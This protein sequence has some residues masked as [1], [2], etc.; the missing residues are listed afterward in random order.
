MLFV[1]LLLGCG[2]CVTVLGL[3][4]LYCVCLLGL[5][6]LACFYVLMF[7]FIAICV[8]FGFVC[9]CVMLFVSLLIRMFSNYD[10]LMFELIDVLV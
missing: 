1:I 4:L 3:C 6:I 9:W 10:W 8:V 7:C 2:V 5:R